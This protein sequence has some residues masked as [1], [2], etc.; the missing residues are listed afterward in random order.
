VKSLLDGKIL[1]DC[2]NPVGANLSHGLQSQISGSETVQE[3]V[4][5]AHVVKAFTIYGYENFED[6]TYAGYGDL[7]PAMLIAGNDQSAKEKV[8]SLCSQLGWESVDTGN[9]S[10]SLHLEHLTLLWIKMA[11]VQGRGAGF[12]WALLQR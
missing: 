3:F 2:T 10:M 11:R 5:N 7:K 8:S 1:V 9:L 4:P 6:S 12:V